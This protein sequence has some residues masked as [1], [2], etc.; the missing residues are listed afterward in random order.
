MCR[1]PRK[2]FQKIAAVDATGFTWTFRIL[3]LLLNRSKYGT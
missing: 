3:L 1:L 2:S